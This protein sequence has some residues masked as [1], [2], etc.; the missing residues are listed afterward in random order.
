[1]Q[2][3]GCQVVVSCPVVQETCL[4]FGHWLQCAAECLIRH[5]LQ[6]PSC[7]VSSTANNCK[8]ILY[9]EFKIVGNSRKTDI[10]L[11]FLLTA[12]AARQDVWKLRCPW[13]APVPPLHILARL[14]ILTISSSSLSCNLPG[15]L[16]KRSHPSLMTR[17]CELSTISCLFMTRWSSS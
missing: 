13:S 5:L 2:S 1:M 16:I 10:L 4:N 6:S 7:P 12:V 17:V 14:P 3:K 8:Q 15:C 9:V 11:V